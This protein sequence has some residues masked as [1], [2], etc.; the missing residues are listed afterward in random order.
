MLRAKEFGSKIRAKSPEPQSELS[1]QKSKRAKNA[2][3]HAKGKRARKH[4]QG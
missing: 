1:A 3:K 4:N 2:W